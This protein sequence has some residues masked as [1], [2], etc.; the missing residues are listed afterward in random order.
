LIRPLA[1]YTFYSVLTFLFWNLSK[2]PLTT[3]IAR[4]ATAYEVDVFIFTECT[5]RATEMLEALNTN[6]DNTFH[7]TDSLCDE[8]VIYTRFSSEFLTK[9][10]ESGRYSIRRLALPGRPDILVASVHLPSQLFSSVDSLSFECARFA[11]A[12][13]KAELG[14]GH[15]RTVVAGDFNLNPFESGMIGALSLHGVMSRDVAEKG[16][17]I[18]QGEKYPFLYNPMWSHFGDRSSKPPGTYFYERAEQNVFFWNMFDQVLIRPD[19]LEMFD[20]KDLEILTDDG[21]DTLLQAN[22]RPDH[23]DGSDHLPVLFRLDL[24]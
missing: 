13:R 10:N 17:R 18:V 11:D 21:E 23:S 4:L 1:T 6:V 16:S 2:K 8:I 20:S 14:I 15:A 9:Y 5:I 12:I 22:G 7:L 19:L 24:R 3:R